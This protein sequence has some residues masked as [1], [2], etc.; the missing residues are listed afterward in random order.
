[1]HPVETAAQGSNSVDDIQP[2]P[3]RCLKG[4]TKLGERRELELLDALLIDFAALT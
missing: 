1:M 3:L 2:S 4:S